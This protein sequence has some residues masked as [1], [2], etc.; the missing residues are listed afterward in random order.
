[1][2]SSPCKRISLPAITH[3]IVGPPFRY[4]GRTGIRRSDEDVIMKEVDGWLDI[5]FVKKVFC[6][7]ELELN[8]F[9][10]IA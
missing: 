6:I 8:S 3:L 10:T 2:G 4:R 5:T 7:K 9:G 1:M